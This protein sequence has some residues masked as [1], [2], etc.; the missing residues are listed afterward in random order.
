MIESDR[1]EEVLQ[2][3]LDSR[4]SVFMGTVQKDKSLE[5][6]AV[7]APRRIENA[8][9]FHVEVSWTLA[10]QWDLRQPQ[11]MC[12][13][14]YSARA[15]YRAMLFG[16]AWICREDVPPANGQVCVRFVAERVHVYNTAGTQSRQLP[17]QAS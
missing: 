14:L 7:H 12:L 3:L 17:H 9:I 1:W 8:W 13:G 11:V 4:L 10:Q 16:K 15:F 6:H 2:H 5:M